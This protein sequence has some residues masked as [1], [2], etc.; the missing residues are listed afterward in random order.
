MTK[1]NPLL[2]TPERNCDNLRNSSTRSKSYYRSI[3]QEAE[4]FLVQCHLIFLYADLRL[5]S[6]TGRLNTKF[7]TLYIESD[8]IQKIHSSTLS[9]TG[10][11]MQ[12]DHLLGISPAQIMAILMIELRKEVQHNKEG[13][14]KA[15]QWKEKS[16]FSILTD[17]SS[18]KK[19][20]EDMA[21]RL[22]FYN[23]MIGKDLKEKIEPHIIS[24]PRL[25]RKSSSTSI[26][27]ESTHFSLAP[28]SGNEIDK[29]T[30]VGSPIFSEDETPHSNQRPQKRMTSFFNQ[31]FNNSSEFEK[32]KSLSLSWSENEAADA[33]GTS[34]VIQNYIN[35]INKKEHNQ[36]GQDSNILLDENKK[37]K[38][39]EHRMQQIMTQALQ[40]LQYGPD[41]QEFFLRQEAQN[42]GDAFFDLAKGGIV[43]YVD[44]AM[45]EDE[46][47]DMIQ[48]A[49]DSRLDHSLDFMSG[50]FKEGS[51]CEAMYKSTANVFWINDWYPLIVSDLHCFFNMHNFLKILRAWLIL[52][53]SLYMK[54]IGLYL[55]HCSRSRREKSLG[56]LPW[57]NNNCRL[58]AYS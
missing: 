40:R 50:F 28:K 30:D 5:L 32:R 7:E 6:A 49:V 37:K 27:I 53:S 36:L 39:N 10:E 19:H 34:K 55:C 26:N 33:N 4:E 31:M 51:M 44:K 42:V 9:G 22:L 8:K 58:E 2:A 29:Q 15:K 23:R 20:E 38:D 56:C 18:R 21:S 52:T 43:N 3:F 14:K 45:T 48:K 57:S 54:I 46:L 24:P 25:E 35:S 1:N 16:F 41:A 17:S 12:T 47:L 11:L 13:G